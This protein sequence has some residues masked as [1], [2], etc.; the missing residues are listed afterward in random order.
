VAD[1]TW[2]GYCMA[3]MKTILFILLLVSSFH[4][5]ASSYE[6]KIERKLKL[7]HDFNV[8]LSGE[9]FELQAKMGLLLEGISRGKWTLVES[10]ADYL[11]NNYI[12]KQKNLEKSLKKSLPDGFVALDLFFHQTAG[13]LRDAAKKRD[14]KTV[15]EK[16]QNLIKT[17][18]ECHA[19][20]ADYLFMDFQGYET[21][22]TVPKKFYKDVNDCR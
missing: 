18:M 15:L 16:H 13:E 3:H 22:S 17:C 21:P 5:R 19:Q 2:A 11:S 1:L 20:Y 8:L 9:M 6:K 4:L 10:T 7:P 14:S 12:L